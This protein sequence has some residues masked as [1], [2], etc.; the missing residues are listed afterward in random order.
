M[1]INAEGPAVG[2]FLR[3]SVRASEVS[4]NSARAASFARS[5]ASLRALNLRYCRLAA[6]MRLI[7]AGPSDLIMLAA[8]DHLPPSHLR[9]GATEPVVSAATSAP[10]A[11]AERV[12]S[13]FV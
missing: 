1:S 9:I 3:T 10:L 7:A 2:N 13:F 5:S 12:K 8:A 11:G 4:F 6:G